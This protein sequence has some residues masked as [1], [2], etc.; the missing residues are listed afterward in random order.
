[1]IFNGALGDG[2]GEGGKEGYKVPIRD[3]T[4]P[5]VTDW[6]FV[7]LAGDGHVAGVEAFLKEEENEGRVD[8]PRDA[9]VRGGSGVV[10][11]VEGW[12]TDGSRYALAEGWRCL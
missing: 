6:E 2:I 11:C 1:M 3:P 4:A 10:E 7:R 9:Y 5:A 8:E 12:L